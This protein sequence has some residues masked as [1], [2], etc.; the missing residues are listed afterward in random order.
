MKGKTRG[1]IMCAILVLSGAL[2]AQ[3]LFSGSNGTVQAVTVPSSANVAGTAP[4][5]TGW[6]GIRLDESGSDMELHMQLF[7]SLGYNA[8]RVSFESP[9]SSPQQEGA[10]TATNLA[11]AIS[12]AKKYNLWIIIDMHGYYDIYPTYQ[13]CWLSNWKPIIQQFS[14]S[15]SQ[16]I[17]QPENEPQS[18]YYGDSQGVSLSQLT[19]GYQAWINQ[20]RSLG[21]THWIVVANGCISTCESTA[22]IAGTMWPT[23]NDSSSRVFLDWHFYMYYPYWSTQGTGWNNA[24][25]ELAATSYY[26]LLVSEMQVTGWPAINTE[27]G[28]DYIGGCPPDIILGPC[29]PSSGTGLGTCDGYTMTTLHFVQKLFSLYES[30]SPRISW[31][32]WPAGSWSTDLCNPPS[33]VSYGALQPANGSFPG[34]W[35]TKIAPPGLSASFVVTPSNPSVNTLLT[36]TAS[37]TGSSPP[38]SY[39][40]KFGDGATGSGASIT[41]AYTSAGTYGVNLTVRD[42]TNKT[43]TVSQSVTVSPPPNFAIVA[44]PGR[45]TIPAGSSGYLTLTVTGLYGFTGSITLA[46]TSSSPSL[47]SSLSSTSLTLTV[48][49]QATSLMTVS[50]SSN[51]SAGNYTLTVTGT[52]AGMT[53]S[54]SIPVAV[55]LPPLLPLQGSINQGPSSP[56]VGQPVTLHA[57]ASNGLQPYS[58]SWSLGDGSTGSGA[59]I[60]HAYATAGNYTVVL[61]IVDSANVTFQVQASLRV[62]SIPVGQALLSAPGSQ[63]I[64]LGSLLKFSISASN[65]SDQGAITLSATNLPP[66]ASFTSTSGNPA[67]GEFSWQPGGSIQPGVYNITFTAVQ[68]GSSYSDSKSVEIRVNPAVTP[69]YLCEFTPMVVPIIS[70]LSMGAIIG[71]AVTVAGISIIRAHRVRPVKLPSVGSL[72]QGLQNRLNLAGLYL[73][74][75]NLSMAIDRET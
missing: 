31:I 66:G 23:V 36:L 11:I 8:V 9:C 45:I 75:S 53:H 12:L 39:S 5:L 59:S 43:V 22:S 38:Y 50:A 10:Y 68:Q 58:F 70:L 1:I 72:R 52:S 26:N 17:W 49:G 7:Q 13:S 67:T 73:Y 63:T 35:A 47:S 57:S 69:C 40:W 51:L 41:H 55:T 32:G 3:F 20:A 30:N 64:F 60:S 14:T 42:A 48:N 65:P 29:N 54:V 62:Q 2:A 6:G 21:D 25:A 46:K 24:T 44:S 56:V 34:G 71:V 27:G 61:V 15:Y 74:S 37:A 33:G 18:N 16:I 19:A 4:V 28:A